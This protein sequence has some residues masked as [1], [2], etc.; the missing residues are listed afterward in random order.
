MK[1]DTMPILKFLKNL[2]SNLG[3]NLLAIVP[4]SPYRYVVTFVTDYYKKLAIS[5]N[6]KLDSTTEDSVFKFLTNVYVTKAAVIY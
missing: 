1:H 6:F 5:E 4:K 3:G 2:Y